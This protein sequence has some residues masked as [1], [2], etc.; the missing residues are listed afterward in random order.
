MQKW[1]YKLVSYKD[2]KPAGI[3]QQATREMLE[4]HLNE[5]GSQ[6]WEIVNVDWMDAYGSEVYFLAIAKRP[7]P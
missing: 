6:G 2:V 3:F 1:E 5:L 4:D 7:R